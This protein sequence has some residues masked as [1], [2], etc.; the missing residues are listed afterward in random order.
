MYVLY[1]YVYILCVDVHL[2]TCVCIYV[3]KYVCRFLCMH[4]RMYNCI[5]VYLCSCVMY[6]IITYYLLYIQ[7][8]P[9]D[10]IKGGGMHQGYPMFSQQCTK[11]WF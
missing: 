5:Y 3:L 8:F 4:V 10:N 9:Q 7:Y 11:Q 6:I 2:T 1:A